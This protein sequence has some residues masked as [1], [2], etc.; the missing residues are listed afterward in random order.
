[1]SIQAHFRPSPMPRRRWT[2]RDVT[3]LFRIELPS[4][5]HLSAALYP[6]PYCYKLLLTL[7]SREL[8]WQIPNLRQWIMWKPATLGP[9][10]CAW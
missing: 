8:A 10:R 3:I 4:R 6:M 7:G 1:M 9:T 5:R 2:D